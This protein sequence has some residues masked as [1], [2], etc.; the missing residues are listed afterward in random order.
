M[1]ACGSVPSLSPDLSDPIYNIPIAPHTP[2]PPS[3][4]F[5]KRLL[6]LTDDV[7]LA[8]RSDRCGMY[9]DK[10]DK[11]N[12]EK[13]EYRFC[14][15]GFC[16][17]CLSRKMR[18]QFEQYSRRLAWMEASGTFESVTYIDVTFP[19]ESRNRA[20]AERDFSYFIDVIARDCDMQDSD[21]PSPR[22]HWLPGYTGNSTNLTAR[23]IIVNPG[24]IHHA[25]TYK[26]WRK[27]F[28]PHVSI[29]V[30][31]VSISHISQL[32][33]DKFLLA[34][35]PA[36][37]FDRAEQEVL[38]M[39]MRRWRTRE[40]PGNADVDLFVRGEELTNISE[41]AGDSAPE[42]QNSQDHCRHCGE[43]FDQESQWFAPDSP[44]PK[45]SEK[46][47]YDRRPHS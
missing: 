1:S 35:P 27:L 26:E 21:F 16:P 17:G 25:T 33:R 31:M 38:F 14:M 42:S 43:I 44:E 9:R 23:A 39:G 32:F 15:C 8:T 24:D 36:D 3:S 22:W 20:D 4:R 41:N 5:A 18:K 30:T 37:G 47:W 28:D 29:N 45:Q 19:H 10:R 46:R 7:K 40:L 2:G 13:R 12:H 6:A 11:N 34:D